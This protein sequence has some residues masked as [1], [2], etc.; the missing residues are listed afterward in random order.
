MFVQI[1]D[2]EIVRGSL[3]YRNTFIKYFRPA[4]ALRVRILALKY[5]YLQSFI[6]LLCEHHIQPVDPE[7]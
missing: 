6:L 3:P 7:A 5:C 1:S 2:K 4:A